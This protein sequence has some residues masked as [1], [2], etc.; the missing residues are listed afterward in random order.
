MIEK[1]FIYTSPEK[2]LFLMKG[3]L[4]I[5]LIAIAALFVVSLA[6]KVVKFAVA[7]LFVG[8][9]LYVGYRFFASQDKH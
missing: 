9:I 6:M 1:H 8:G 5:V 3:I 7:L 4:K 2:I